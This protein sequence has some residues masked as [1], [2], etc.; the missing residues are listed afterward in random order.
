[1]RKGYLCHQT[2]PFEGCNESLE[3]VKRALNTAGLYGTCMAW[4]SSRITGDKG[5]K[6]VSNF[7]LD[8][9]EGI[10][11]PRHAWI[12]ALA[13]ISSFPIIVVFEY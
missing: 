2:K 13:S 1:M 7:I 6:D 3:R 4:T 11:W 5:L 8:P 9:M 10:R 12:L